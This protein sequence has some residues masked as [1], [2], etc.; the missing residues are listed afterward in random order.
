MLYGTL[1]H[2]YEP[3]NGSGELYSSPRAQMNTYFSH[4]A[5][6]CVYRQIISYNTS[7]AYVDTCRRLLCRESVSYRFFNK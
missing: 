1:V 2:K 3:L 5:V 6:G 4:V 7:H